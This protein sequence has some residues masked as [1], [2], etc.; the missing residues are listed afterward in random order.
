MSI[1]V[2]TFAKSGSMFLYKLFKHLS[3]INNLDHY[4]INS[5]NLKNYYKNDGKCKIIC[6]I[7]SIPGIKIMKGEICQIPQQEVCEFSELNQYIIHSRNPLDLLISQYYSFGF[8]HPGPRPQSISSKTIDE[9]CTDLEVV[10][11]INENY[12]KL[13]NWI[14]K[15]GDKPNVF[16]SNYDDMY[17]HFETWITNIIQFL[18]LKGMY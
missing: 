1:Q 9:Y 17:Y 12:H 6:P 11:Q 14:N 18:K 16:I 8:T 2:F 5:G 3:K 10:D 4:S 13:V 7:R 15:Y